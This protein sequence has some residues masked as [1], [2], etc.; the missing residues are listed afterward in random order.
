MQDWHT[1]HGY[2]TAC[3][4][5][6]KF[7]ARAEAD[8]LQLKS[9]IALLHDAFLESID[10]STREAAA[11]SQSI[12]TIVERCILLR[13]MIKMTPAELKK[14]EMEWHEAYLLI[15]ETIGLLEEQIAKLATVGKTSH[16]LDIYAWKSVK[17]VTRFLTGKAFVATVITTVLL[18]ALV[19]LP[20][21]KVYTYD[22]LDKNPSTQASYRVVRNMLRAVLPDIMYRDW[23]DYVKTNVK[24]DEDLKALKFTRDTPAETRRKDLVNLIT[25]T[26]TLAN[27][28]KEKPDGELARFNRDNPYDTFVVMFDNVAS[29]KEAMEL[30]EK[31][32]LA[33]NVVEFGKKF[34]AERSANVVAIASPPT[35]TNSPFVVEALRLVL[36][37]H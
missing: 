20:Y 22:A 23:A 24:T 12:I 16:Y 17:R 32:K 2:L 6:T 28:S 7:D 13:Q 8:F 3:L 9:Q 21:F 35:T 10:T 26:G 36:Q 29:A 30:F 37:K 1:F 25:S 19:V 11:I 15:N 18:I 14:M 33:D 4:K 31:R 34:Q 27:V 5:G